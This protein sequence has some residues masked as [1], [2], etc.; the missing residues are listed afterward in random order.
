M[1][2]YAGRPAREYSKGMGQRLGIAQA[3]VNEPDLLVL[4]EPTSGLDPVAHRMV[5]DL[6]LGLRDRGT[7][8]L[9]SSHLLSDVEDVCDRIGV[10]GGGKVLLEGSVKELLAEEGALQVKVRGLGVAA[11]RQALR[12][13]G[14]DV[15]GLETPHGSLDDLF[16]K[17]I[18]GGGDGPGAAG[19]PEPGEG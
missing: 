16:L 2:E 14:G 6:L 7:T 19:K 12:S 8:I 13:A 11:I 17:A 10:L 5:K 1:G 15:E 4:D 3:L 18:G 9:I